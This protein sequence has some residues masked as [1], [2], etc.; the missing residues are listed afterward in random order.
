MPAV[1]WA[2]P[3]PGDWVPA[4][5]QHATRLSGALPPGV[6]HVSP[7][8][9]PPSC[10][11][12]TAGQLLRLRQLGPG[13]EVAPELLPAATVVM[14]RAGYATTAGVYGW[15]ALDGWEHQGEPESADA[16]EQPEPADE[17]IGQLL[18]SIQARL[19]QWMRAEGDLRYKLEGAVFTVLSCLDGVVDGLPPFELVPDGGTAA[20]NRG[21]HLHDEWG[22]YCLGK[23]G[24]DAPKEPEP[25]TPPLSEI[26]ERLLRLEALFIDPRELAK[27]SDDEMREMAQM[28]GCA[29]GELQLGRLL[30]IEDRLSL[31]EQAIARPGRRD[32]FQVDFDP[33]PYHLGRIATV[34]ERAAGV[35]EAV[36][37]A[38]GQHPD[39]MDA[40]GEPCPN[41]GCRLKISAP[42]GGI[43]PCPGCGYLWDEEAA[44]EPGAE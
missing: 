10:V 15:T 33:G 13:D 17:L 4:C 23:M 39:F 5:E 9:K 35:Q 16:D 19:P 31:L 34:L 8:Y 27:L 28:P 3:E 22:R 25:D 21:V 20:I 36:A 6:G 40:I 26:M 24:D 41:C 11:A 12:V 32:A 29:G 37:A 18:E 43:A 38:G 44:P 42:G 14:G 1:G 30:K 2:R 7:S